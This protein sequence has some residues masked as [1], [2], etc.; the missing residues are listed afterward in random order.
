MARRLL[1]LEPP[2]LVSIA[3]V[4]GVGVAASATPWFKGQAP[5]YNPLDVATH[6]GY[7]NAYLD[8]R[9]LNPVYW[10]LA[11]EFQYYVLVGLIF[12]V[13]VAGNQVTRI[14][15][16]STLASM[17]I[18]L[19]SVGGWFIAYYLPI[20]SAG[21]LTFLLVQR[22]ISALAYWSGI[23][24]LAAYM[25]YF[26]GG[27]AGATTAVA[28]VATAL[29]LAYIRFPHIA[30]V[31]WLGTLSYSLYLLHVPISAK[32][33]NITARL[34]ITQAVEILAI[35]LSFAAS[36]FAAYLLYMF[37]EKPSQAAAKRI[38]YAEGMGASGQST[39]R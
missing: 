20:F 2:Y 19:P 28:T 17:P 9:W 24:A 10:T 18:L 4:I 5:E 30:V 38:G 1:R 13:L 31:A 33:I 29:A 11:I 26:S 6:V 8:K 34:G 36:L 37:V 25:L 23:S 22:L 14:A 15:A 12:P 16:V 27:A 7:L 3:V 21:I 35:A 32:V 39:L